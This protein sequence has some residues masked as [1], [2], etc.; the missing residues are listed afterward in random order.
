MPGV[1]PAG[2]MKTPSG[3][4]TLKLVVLLAS[5]T[6]FIVLST[7]CKKALIL[8]TN[9]RPIEIVMDAGGVTSSQSSDVVYKICKD[10]NAAAGST[11][12]EVRYYG[13]DGRLVPDKPNNRGLTM[14]GAVRSEAAANSAAAD[15]VNV[16]QKATFATLNGASD[17]IDKIK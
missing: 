14:T 15:P 10:L 7:A 8:P 16:T 13:K 4:F 12:C 5:A 6:A 17:F 1:K 11:V 2:A 3:T 9:E